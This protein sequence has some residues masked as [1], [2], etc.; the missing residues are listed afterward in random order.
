MKS[1]E[2][3][4]SITLKSIIA[5]VT[6]NLSKKQECVLIVNDDDNCIISALLNLLKSINLFRFLMFNFY[7]FNIY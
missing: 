4:N 2:D 7:S 5:A 1:Q 6:E 3:L